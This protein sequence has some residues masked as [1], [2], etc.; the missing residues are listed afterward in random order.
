MGCAYTFC[1]GY[2]LQGNKGCSFAN[3]MV[4]NVIYTPVIVLNI[5]T[6]IEGPASMGREMLCFAQSLP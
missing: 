1:I 5:F 3:F 4:Q 6:L 2:E